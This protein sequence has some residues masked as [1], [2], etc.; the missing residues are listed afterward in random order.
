MSLWK[1]VLKG[2][3]FKSKKGSQCDILEHIIS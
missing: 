1:V 2:C 3:Y